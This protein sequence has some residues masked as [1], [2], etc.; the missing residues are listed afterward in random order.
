M[1]SDHDSSRLT[2][3]ARVH[4]GNRLG[5]LVAVACCAAMGGCFPLFC[6]PGQAV[7][8]Y[9]PYPNQPAVLRTEAGETFA[10]YRVKYWRFES[11]PPAL[12][13]EY[14]S[15]VDVADTSSIRKAAYA[16][17]PTFEPYVDSAELRDAIL[18]ATRLRRRGVGLSSIVSIQ[19]FSVFANRDSGGKWF[20]R[21]EAQPLASRCVSDRS[22]IFEP[23]GARI[24][25]TL[26]RDEAKL[27]R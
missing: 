24:P 15:P 20:F 11:A 22:G 21:G 2:Q 16:I 23:S 12:Q 1:A 18:T 17:W 14:E 4:T 6:G 13:L 9:G 10:V 7:G 8:Q 3:A 5:E 27:L 26:G 25:L 19:S